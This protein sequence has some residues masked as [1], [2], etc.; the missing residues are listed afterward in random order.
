MGKR[1][2]FLTL[3]VA[4]CAGAIVWAT[5]V[6]DNFTRT[7]SSSTLGANWTV[8]SGG[9]AGIFRNGA[10]CPGTNCVAAWT[11]NTFA[12]DQQST[13]TLGAFP[14]HNTSGPC[15]RVQNDGLGNGYCWLG[16]SIY[17]V[18]SG[19]GTFIVSGCSTSAM[20]GDTFQLIVTG[21]TLTTKYNGVADCTVTDATYSSGFTG[22][23]FSAS[24]V[25]L[26]AF[27]GGPIGGGGS[28]FP[29][30]IIT[31]PVRGGS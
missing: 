23:T 28:A 21:T 30:A 22:M 15:V 13:V 9:P 25:T 10:Y 16:N 29:A 6:T 31:N 1:R 2:A 5:D 27:D 4:L 26:S 3:G 19:I 7:D 12:N 24:N 14:G 8:E 20:T 17:R 11:A 18:V